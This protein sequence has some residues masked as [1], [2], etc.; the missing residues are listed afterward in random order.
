LPDDISNLQELQVL[1]MSENKISELPLGFYQL[2]NLVEIDLSYNP[3]FYLDKSNVEWEKIKKINLSNTPFGCFEKNIN[4]LKQK[5]PNCEVL[6]GSNNRY[7][8][9]GD[10]Y[11]YLSSIKRRL[12]NDD[13]KE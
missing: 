5:F 6:G 11:F 1:K 12:S 3:I 4:F 2:K 13:F 9:N 8:E 7:Y 10:N